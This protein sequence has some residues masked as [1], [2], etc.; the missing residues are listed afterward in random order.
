[1]SVVRS[2]EN[3]EHGEKQLAAGRWQKS[4]VRDLRSEEKPISDL[5]LLTSVMDDLNGLNDLN[6]GRRTTDKGQL[7]ACKKA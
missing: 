7:L 5:R 1:M 2:I 3:M 4:E 6:K